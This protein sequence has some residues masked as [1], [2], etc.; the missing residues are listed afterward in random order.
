MPGRPT[1]NLLPICR[2]DL[3]IGQEAAATAAWLCFPGF[4]L[5]PPEQRY[6]RIASATYRY[7][8]A[9]GRFVADREVNAAGLVAHYPMAH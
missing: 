2:L 9:G 8:N 3:A 6:R 4:T 5:E 7:T 1:T